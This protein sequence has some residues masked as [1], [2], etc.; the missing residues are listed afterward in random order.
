M[1]HE[2]LKNELRALG[3]GIKARHMLLKAVKQH[4]QELRHQIGRYLDGLV[5]GYSQ[6]ARCR[7]EVAEL[8]VCDALRE[9]LRQMSGGAS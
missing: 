8:E 5:T 3:Y 7:P 4:R 1:N 2:P 9:I 6:R